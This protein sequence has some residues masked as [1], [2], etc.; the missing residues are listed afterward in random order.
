[1]LGT[2]QGFGFVERK[3]EVRQQR[4]KGGRKSTLSN[5][6]TLKFFIRGVRNKSLSSKGNFSIL[7]I[8]AKVVPSTSWTVTT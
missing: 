4:R 6:V 2:Q 7:I 1:M 5:T 3:K 8:E